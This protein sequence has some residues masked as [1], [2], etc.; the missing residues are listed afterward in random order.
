MSLPTSKITLLKAVLGFALFTMIHNPV[1]FAQPRRTPPAPVPDAVV[2]TRP[3]ETQLLRAESTLSTFMNGL[4]AEESAVFD[5]YPYLLNITP[6]P[7]I[8]SA[9]VPNL[10]PNFRTKHEANKIVAAAGDIDV[11]F[12][13]DSITDFWRNETGNYAGKPI[14][15]EYFSD[16]KIANFGIAGDTTQGVL[17][18]LENGEGVGYSP[19]AIM[20]MIGTN[21]ARQNI[22]GEIAEG[23]G[24]IVLSLQQHFP[25]AKILL[26]GIFPRSTPD[27]PLRPQLAEVN[28]TISHLHDGNT[29]FYKDIGSVFL[30]ADGTI[31][32]NIMIDGLHPSTMGYRL[33]AEAVEEDLR[34]LLR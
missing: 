29:V 12:M 15:D 21:N 4:S 32:T 7:A 5:T 30:A 13:G 8:N 16:L 9:I 34:A 2:M 24:A 20:L 31:P 1:V 10:S 11:L 33:W 27:S 3:S 17:Y 26:L 14:Q 6:R 25:A 23:V 18:R 28:E 19:E 22:A